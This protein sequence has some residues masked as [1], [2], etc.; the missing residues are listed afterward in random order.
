MADNN[1]NLNKIKKS[2]EEIK[3][4]YADIGK[5][6]PFEG[7]EA[8]SANSREVNKELKNSRDLLKGI[9]EDADEL[10][11]FCAFSIRRG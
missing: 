1:Q 3:R 2:L 8:A 6:N 4:N 11:S 9:N 7:I 10:T 5:E